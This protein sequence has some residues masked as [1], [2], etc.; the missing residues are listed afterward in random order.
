MQGIAPGRFAFAKR[1]I[2]KP[3][4]ILLDYGCF[5]GDFILSLGDGLKICGADRNFDALRKA[6]EKNPNSKFY[7]LEENCANLPDQY[8]DTIVCLEV[9]EHVP[10]EKELLDS[11]YEKLKPG[12]SLI[13]SVPHKGLFEFL[14][15]GNFKFRFPFL[16]KAYYKLII[17]DMSM[18]DAR[19]V[20]N[21]FGMFGDISLSESMWHRHYSFEELVEIVGGKFTIE[22]VEMYGLLTPVFDI[23]KIL[24]CRV[25]NMEFMEEMIC[26]VSALDE[27]IRFGRMSYSIIL[28]LRKGSV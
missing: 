10:V 19:F 14:D 3:I 20:S 24:L 13:L 8:F 7:F 9:M 26:N 5:N 6:Q 23:A 18:Y 2:D 16:L 21:P 15:T 22:S 4:G 27:R 28:K 12:G 11:L 25:L 1:M 17:K